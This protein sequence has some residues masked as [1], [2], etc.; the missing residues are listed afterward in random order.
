M[1]KRYSI[2]QNEMNECWFCGAKKGLHI[3]EVFFGTA[4]R[5][6]SIRYGCCVSL[7][8]THHN[9]SN[10]SVHYNRDMDL[11]LKREMQKKF[12]ETYPKLDF[13]KIFGKSYL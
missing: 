13:I 8:G 4:K 2:L 5:P 3:H 11:N 6:L 7:C 1:I 9:L 12:I 10:M